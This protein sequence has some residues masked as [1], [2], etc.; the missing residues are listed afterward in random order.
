M[1]VDLCAGRGLSVEDI[2][3]ASINSPVN[4]CEASLGALRSS[5]AT[6]ESSPNVYGRS[7]GLGAL[8]SVREGEWEGRED[9]V[10]VEHD[11]GLGPQAPRE[12]VRAAM[13]VRASQ[14]AQGYAPVRP[15]VS[16]RLAEALNADVVPVVQLEGSVGASGD[17]APLARIARCIYRGDGMAT[18]RGRVVRCSEALEQAGLKP[19]EL[20]PGEALAIINSNAFSVGMAAL[21]VCASLRLIRE[22]LRA[23]SKT[24]SVTG[25]NPQHFSEAVADSKRLGG[26]REVIESM[27]SSAC[28]K[29]PRLQDP[30]CIRCVPQVYGAALEALRFAEGVVEAEASSSSDNPFVSGGSVYHACNFHAAGAAIAAD[31]AKVALAHVGNMVERRTAHLLSQ[32]TTGLPDFL[33]VKGTVVG[34]MIYQYAAASLAAKLRLL[35]SPGSVHSIP[36]SGAQE[37]V[38]S[39]APNA[40]LDLL[41]ASAALARL[42]AVEDALAS[43]AERVSGGLQPQD[44]REAIETSVRRVVEAVGLSFL[45]GLA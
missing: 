26:V 22:S 43:Q 15:E 45:S 5:R 32:Q 16:A 25:C 39:M 7:T 18:Y 34:A 19:I 13:V 40:A 44:P 36:T 20:A 41:R 31:V 1:A 3:S 10:L 12:V 37:D 38:V 8:A 17:L 27:A 35:A 11:V 4:I 9:K 42:I 24:L 28:A 29:A 23:L 14:M 2:C 6:Y 30:Y 21:G 33:A